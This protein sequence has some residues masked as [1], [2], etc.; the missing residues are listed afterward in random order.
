MG[1]QMI[2]EWQIL[3]VAP[4]AATFPLMENITGCVVDLSGPRKGRPLVTFPNSEPDAW[5]PITCVSYRRP[6]T[7][8]YVERVQQMLSGILFVNPEIAKDV[9]AQTER[10]EIIL[11][12]RYLKV[13][14]FMFNDR[15]RFVANEELLNLQEIEKASWLSRMERDKHGLQKLK[16]GDKVQIKNSVLGLHGTVNRVSGD[17]IKVTLANGFLQSAVVSRLMLD[18]IPS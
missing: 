1:E 5:T 15:M 12:G 14:Q 11:G 3:T 13:A 9:I 10:G 2:K 18:L 17:Q 16:P 8:T 4:F 7:S 6:R